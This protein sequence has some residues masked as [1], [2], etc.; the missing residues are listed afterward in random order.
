MGTISITWSFVAC[1][2]SVVD[3]EAQIRH[4]IHLCPCV[5]ARA[6]ACTHVH[7]CVYSSIGHGRHDMDQNGMGRKDFTLCRVGEDQLSGGLA[8]PGGS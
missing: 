7:I 2:Q 8:G 1:K 4:G 3:F 6:C 5:C